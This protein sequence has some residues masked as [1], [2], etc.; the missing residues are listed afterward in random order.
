MGILWWAGAVAAIA[1]SGFFMVGMGPFMGSF[2]TDPYTALERHGTDIML[3][4]VIVWCLS[5]LSLTWIGRMMWER[6]FVA[7]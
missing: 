1:I 5:I 7:R 2:W 6:Y 4:W 3:G